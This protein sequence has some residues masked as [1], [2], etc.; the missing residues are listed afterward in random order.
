MSQPQPGSDPREGGTRTRATIVGSWEVVSSLI[1]VGAVL[2]L[3]TTTLATF[4]PSLAAALGVTSDLGLDLMS[5]LGAGG[6]ALGLLLLVLYDASHVV[7]VIDS[8]RRTIT[9]WRSLLSLRLFSRRE[10]SFDEVSAVSQEI[11][12]RRPARGG[13]RR[14]YSARYRI[15]FSGSDVWTVAHTGYRDRARAITT[16]LKAL[17]RVMR[18]EGEGAWPGGGH[19]SVATWIDRQRAMYLARLTPLAVFPVAAVLLSA[20]LALGLV[21]PDPERDPC[22]A[23]R[24]CCEDVGRGDCSQIERMDDSACWSAYQS[25]RRA[26]RCP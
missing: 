6:F 20:G 10:R 14:T 16:I 21:A 8:E 13:S 25:A 24:A 26:R 5:L 15:H 9:A 19:P 11:F 3:L 18:R 22:G 12:T 7:T 1:G 4:A 23:L 2:L 17:P